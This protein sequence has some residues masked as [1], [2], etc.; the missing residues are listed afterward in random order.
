MAQQDDSPQSGL[1]IEIIDHSGTDTAP[2]DAP[3]GAVPGYVRKIPLLLLIPGLLFTGAVIGLYVQPPGVQ[4]FFDLVG[5][6]P[7]GGSDAPFALPPDLDVPQDMLETLQI[8]DV[9]GLARLEPIGGI[10]P[11]PS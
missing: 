3:H 6:E 1:P 9:V 11:M 10:S 7:G 5:L 8:S 4:K 2:G